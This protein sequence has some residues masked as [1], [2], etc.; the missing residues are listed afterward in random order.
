MSMGGQFKFEINEEAYFVHNIRTSLDY[1][2]EDRLSHPYPALLKI[3]IA[4]ILRFVDAKQARIRNLLRGTILRV[5]ESGSYAQEIAGSAEMMDI[6]EEHVFKTLPEAYEYLR[7]MAYN[8]VT[9]S[10]FYEHLKKYNPSTLRCYSEG[11]LIAEPIDGMFRLL[12]VSSSSSNAS[13]GS[14]SSSCPLSTATSVIADNDSPALSR[15]PSE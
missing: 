15:S 8:Y 3:R 14:N 1:S 4:T 5:H 13:N 2:I 9:A 11:K 7:T 10:T 6:P 12:I